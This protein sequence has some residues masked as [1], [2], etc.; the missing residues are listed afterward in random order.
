MHAKVG[1]KAFGNVR[2]SAE[3]REWQVLCGDIDQLCAVFGGVL[4]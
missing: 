2:A 4:V 1:R 3:D